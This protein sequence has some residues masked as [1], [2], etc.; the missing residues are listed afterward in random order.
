VASTTERHKNQMEQA[1]ASSF[2]RLFLACFPQNTKVIGAN[3]F[4]SLKYITT[5]ISL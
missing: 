1:V 2:F 4:R 3:T 5:K